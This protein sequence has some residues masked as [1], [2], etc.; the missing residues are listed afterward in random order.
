VP[1]N[2]RG[3]RPSGRSQPGAWAAAVFFAA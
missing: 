3:W 2:R 1:G